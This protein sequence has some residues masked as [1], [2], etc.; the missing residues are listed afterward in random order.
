MITLAIAVRYQTLLC[1]GR[2]NTSKVAGRFGARNKNADLETK[3]EIKHKF[4]NST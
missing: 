3:R 4:N 1:K 2:R